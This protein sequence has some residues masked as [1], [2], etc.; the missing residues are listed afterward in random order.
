MAR[1][2][3]FGRF[4]YEELGLPNA[5][6]PF[7]QHR[8]GIVLVTGATGSGKSTTLAAMIHDL[9]QNKPYHIVTIEDPIEFVHKPIQSKITQ[10]EV[11]SD[12]QSFNEG[13]RR[14]VRQS[15]DVIMIGEMRDKES[16]QVALAAALTGHLV[17]ATLHTI[18]ASQT[19]QRIMSYFPEHA[20]AQVAV[21][22]SFVSS[23]D[24]ISKTGTKD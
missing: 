10:R 7:A 1:F 9:N 13:L 17:L 2:L 6:K 21:D 19:L 11:G 18:D 22:L 24:R 8:S 5:I 3:P 12:T 4:S 15:P 16:I 14:V 20:R 23:R